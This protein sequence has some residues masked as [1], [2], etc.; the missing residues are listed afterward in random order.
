V[1]TATTTVEALN[2]FILVRREK[3][4]FSQ[5]LKHPPGNL[6]ISHQPSFYPIA[7]SV[8]S[9]REQ[10]NFGCRLGLKSGAL[11]HADSQPSI[12]NH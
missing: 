6:S 12:F 11:L 2:P 8:E 9:D 1:E 10:V 3:A 7:G 5:W 4:R